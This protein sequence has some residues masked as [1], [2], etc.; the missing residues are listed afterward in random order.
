MATGQ[1]RDAGAA[2]E[3]KHR[4]GHRRGRDRDQQARKTWPSLQDENQY[5][6]ASANRK[7]GDVRASGPDLVDDS[8]QLTYRSVCLHREA[9]ELRDLTQHD[10]ER[11]PV[12]VPVA[13]RFREQLGDE[14]EA[15]ES[16]RR[17]HRAGDDRHQSAN[18]DRALRIAGRQR[19]HHRQDHR[20]ERRVRSKHQNTARP[21]SAYATSGTMVA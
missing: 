1:P 20:G 3:V 15:R 21:N 18:R 16:S 7:R 6:R 19:Q 13:D 9:E 5:Q 4:D 17:A 14:A 12:H 8:K 11:D 2:R 10:G